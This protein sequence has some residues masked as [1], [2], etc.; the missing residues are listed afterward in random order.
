VFGLPRGAFPLSPVA[1]SEA[2]MNPRQQ[3]S[4]LHLTVRY[5]LIL[6]LLAG[7]A[8]TNFLILRAEIQNSR[9]VAELITNSEGDSAPLHK[10]AT[11]RRLHYIENF[12]FW[13]FIGTIAVLLVSGAFVFRPMIRRVQ[14]DMESLAE[15]NDS[16]ERRVAQRTAEAEHRSSA[17]V[18]SEAALRDQSRVLSSILE[19]MGDGV[20]VLDSEAR[21]QLLNPKARAILNIADDQLPIEWSHDWLEQFGVR[22]F[23]A[24]G[25][26][27][28]PMDTFPLI[29]S[30]RG[31]DVDR[32]QVCVRRA[33]DSVSWL[34]ITSRPVRDN[35]GRVDGS[36]G[37]LRDTTERKRAEDAL[38]KSET[39]YR[40]LVNNLPLYVMRKDLDGRFTWV[41]ENFCRLVNQRAADVIGKTDY[42]FYSADVANRNRADDERVVQHGIIYHDVQVHR[43]LDGEQI[44]LEVLKTP[45]RNATGNIVETQTILLD[46][47]AR[48]E[49]ERRLLESERLAAIGQ[50]VAGVAHESRN[51]L[52]QIQACCGLLQWKLDGQSE[53]EEL[54]VDLQK[55]QDR[56]RRLFD[57]LRE[58]AAPFK[59]DK[60]ICDLRDVAQEAW[61]TLEPQRSNRQVSLEIEAENGTSKCNVDRLQLEQV[62]RNVFENSLA[63][64][65]DPATIKVVMTSPPSTIRQDLQVEII[66]NGPGLTNEQQN[67]AF[68]PFYTTK[69]KGTGL[70]MAITKRI[71]EA[72]D[73]R[74]HIGNAPGGGAI[75]GITLPR[76]E[77]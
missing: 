3:I 72:H 10:Q 23:Q 32:E 67:R 21:F 74:I 22:L 62:F 55:A 40:S 58:Y 41:N 8:L 66:D 13:S 68:E 60:R 2:G 9:R 26:E 48:V 1:E 61:K 69:S 75:V 71:I 51:A 49:A 42:D 5:L 38:R 31:E 47:T 4:A 27:L 65:A 46:I 50:M 14:S 28:F 25:V 11:L 29:R 17:L 57:D 19:N 56:L 16:L 53:V 52:Q 64:C 33:D 35:A 45:V 73:G 20:M 76:G 7:L 63:A 43:T 30:L 44:H 34:S 12:A 24:D 15:L 70:G 54:L 6:A 77:V 59:M 36:V 18:L 39:L 37:V